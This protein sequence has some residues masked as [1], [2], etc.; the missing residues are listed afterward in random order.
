MLCSWLN[1]LLPLL[2]PQEVTALYSELR[3]DGRIVAFVLTM[4][5]VSAFLAAIV[6]ALR[7]SRLDPV[8]ALK[9]M[10]A[11]PGRSWFS[12]RSGLVVS[13]VAL[14]LVL[15]SSGG[16]LLKS[17]LNSRQLDPGFRLRERN[18]LF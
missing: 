18:P 16:L 8:G 10:E 2:T 5:L 9:G 1:L 11:V 7:S 6:P 17:F 12:L 13:Q 3:V 14:S 4:S 15:L